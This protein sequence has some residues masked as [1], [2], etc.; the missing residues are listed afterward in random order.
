MNDLLWNNYVEIILYKMNIYIVNLL[1]KNDIIY[2]K[3]AIVILLVSNTNDWKNRDEVIAI[4]AEWDNYKVIW[5]YQFGGN[6]DISHP[7]GI[8][9]IWKVTQEGIERI[10]CLINSTDTHHESYVFDI[11]TGEIIER[12]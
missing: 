10:A 3:Y 9:K 8:Q 6:K 2:N 11:E 12:N 1:E 7:L 5:T 4:R